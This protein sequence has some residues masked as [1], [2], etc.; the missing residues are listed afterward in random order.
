ML[1]IIETEWGTEPAIQKTCIYCNEDFWLPDDS[2]PSARWGPFPIC[3]ACLDAYLAEH[4][5]DGKQYLSDL[6]HDMR[7]HG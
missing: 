5:P 3:H 6:E 2:P 4:T 7:L 1:P